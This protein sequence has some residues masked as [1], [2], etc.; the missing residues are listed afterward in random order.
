M[1]ELNTYSDLLEFLDRL[2]Q[3]AL[4]KEEESH[5]ENREHIQDIANLVLEK[6]DE[7]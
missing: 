2:L 7:F 1:P 5:A 4:T 6:M 3:Y